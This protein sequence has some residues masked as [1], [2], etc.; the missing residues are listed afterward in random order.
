[1]S[2]KNTIFYKQGQ[3]Y[4]LNFSA[5]KIS[6]DA[7]IFLA[8]KI[9]CKYNII[10]DISKLISDSRDQSLIR[11]S[12][13]SILKQRVFLMMQGYEDANDVNYLKNDPVI[14][15]ILGGDLASQ[16][17]ISRFE[18]TVDKQTIFKILYGWL[19]RYVRS[20]KGRKTVIID[21]DATDDPTYGHQQLSL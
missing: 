15:N 7:S 21:I 6:S 5:E 1:M 4:L 17:T 18:N 14:K 9:E 20:L 19:D 11:F 3:E 8:E 13:E 10:R 12:Y 2:T 16:P